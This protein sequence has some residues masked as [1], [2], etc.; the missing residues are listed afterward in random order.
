MA[1]PFQEQARK[2]KILYLVLILALFT[3]TLV[4]RTT[5]VA[6]QADQLAIREESRGEV[7]LIGALIRE[8]LTGSRGVAICLLWTE[9]IEA[10]KKNQ[11]NELEVLV[12]ALTKLQ[13][14]FITPWL[15][16]S[17]NLS[18]NVSVE[19]D[20]VRD[21]YFYVSRGVELLA[22]GE[23]QN[24]Y[25]PD[26][27]WSI[28]FYLQHKICMSDETNYQRSLFQLSL[29]PPNERDPAR[30][31]ER[32]ADGESV[33]NYAEFLKFVEEHPQLVR[34]LREGMYR[35]S[36]REKKRLFTCE[37][38]E[39]VVQFLED[40]FLVPSLYRV[41][42]A[43]AATSG[44]LRTWDP[45]KKDE[46]LP[47]G[48]GFPALPPPH[49]NAFDPEALTFESTLHD[50]TD[51]YAIAQS[52]YSY[53]QEPIPEPG[54][55]P[56]E[57]KPI[58][59]RTRQ[60]RPRHMTTLIFRNYPSQGRRYMAERLQQ[61]GWYDEEPWDAS[62]WFE[63]AKDL[64]REQLEKSRKLGGGQ[65]WSEDA[66]KRAYQAWDKHGVA[67]HLMFPNVAAERTKRDLAEAFHKR[68]G[69]VAGGPV[70]PMR[71]E[72]LTAQE[73]LEYD[74][75]RY[76]FEYNFYR[77]LSNFAH[78]HLRAFSESQPETVAARKLFFL[79]EQLNLA[80]SPSPALKMYQT[81]VEVPA[82]R[83]RKFSPLEAWREL[84][85][86][87]KDTAGKKKLKEYG[88]DSFTQ[89]QTAE[90]Q[91]R[92]QLL[93]NRFEG[94]KLKEDVGNM[95]KLLPLV[96]PFTHDTFRPPV[97]LGPFDG[98]DDYRTPLVEDRIVDLIMERMRLPTRRR[99][100]PPRPS[101]EEMRR[102]VPPRATPASEAPRP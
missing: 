29:I 34:R 9:A 19:C 97:F 43:L 36:Q 15:F 58:T 82:W 98:T 94:R 46:P 80:G 16:Q 45:H 71:E 1:S 73:K 83:G 50:S 52:W 89:E 86:M 17:W 74:A 22:E 14:H 69:I 32:T 62:D 26:L 96:P 75:A 24:R 70:P 54:E 25:H 20:R 40:N 51:A 72:D 81:P 85:L 33:F 68:F 55:L 48:E 67:N 93:Y 56:G 41:N 49:E 88:R 35:D 66:W 27:R 61:E 77:A 91:I 42:T 78:H 90:Y 92:Y 4:W 28:G 10:Q 2:R 65:K 31:W 44:Q 53:A 12:R 79:A 5:V 13:P 30:F 63:Q 84:V 60:R 37:T 59:D 99:P 39:A 101:P 102:R 3:L 8:C 7:D 87:E 21:K 100:L 23:R 57:T 47:K 64:S 11:W 38:P 6:R 76:M 18:Y 95:A